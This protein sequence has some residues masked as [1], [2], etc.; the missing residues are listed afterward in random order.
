MSIGKRLRELREKIGLNQESIGEICEVSK[1]MV[2]QWENDIVTP[3]IERM[4]LLHSKYP[5]DLN[6]L[7][8]SGAEYRPKVA[9]LHHIAEQ[10][11]DYAIEE[12]TKEGNS[13]IKLIKA[14]QNTKDKQ[15][16]PQ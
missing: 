2:S 8:I 6:W 13:F 16:Q 1:S 11:P 15:N 7:Y 12:L 3:P 9:V 5:F 10:L 4:L 14:G